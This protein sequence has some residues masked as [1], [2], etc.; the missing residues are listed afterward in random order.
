MAAMEPLRAGREPYRIPAVEVDAGDR[1]L[2][3]LKEAARSELKVLSQFVRHDNACDRD[4]CGPQA[5][6]DF[7]RAPL[8]APS[9][10]LAIDI[11]VRGPTTLYRRKFW[12]ACPRRIPEHPTQ[13]DPLRVGFD[14]ECDPAILSPALVDICGQ[15]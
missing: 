1:M 6:E 15:V 12:S 11:I 2:H 7:I 10:D 4:A 3:V 9:G 13:R 14:R 8:P 5:I